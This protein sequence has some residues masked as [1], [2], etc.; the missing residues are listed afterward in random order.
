MQVA[1]TMTVEVPQLERLCNLLEQFGGSVMADFSALITNMGAMQETVAA[2]LL[3]MQA[4]T[5]DQQR[6]NTLA[7]ALADMNQQL[8][9]AL[10]QPPPPPPA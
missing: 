4:D 5:V 8:Q 7:A 6:V 2:I 10:P 1:L 3:E 9:A